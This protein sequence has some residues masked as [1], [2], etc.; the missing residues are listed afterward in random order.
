[1]SETEHPETVEAAEK[2][3]S[4]REQF[5]ALEIPPNIDP[6][7]LALWLQREQEELERQ[8]RTKKPKQDRT[9]HGRLDRLFAAFIGVAVMC[10]VIVLGLVQGHE[11]QTILRHACLAFLAYTILG[12]VA[13][14]IAEYCVSDSVETLLREIVKR[15]EAAAAAA[16]RPDETTESAAPETAGTTPETAS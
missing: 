16:T 11:P 1:M 3:A 4:L 13:G 10:L 12:F 8:S 15:S 6:R 7:L 14:C 9:R 2:L 5:E